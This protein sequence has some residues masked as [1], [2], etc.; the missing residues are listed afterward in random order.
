M[1]SKP[2]VY[3]ALKHSSGHVD[4]D[5]SCILSLVNQGNDQSEPAKVGQI[6][7]RK[8]QWED[9]HHL[10]IEDFINY[11]VLYNKKELYFPN[12]ELIIQATIHILDS[13]IDFVPNPIEPNDDNK[14]LFRTMEDAD[15]TI[16]TADGN[17]LKAHSNILS[18][19]SEIFKEILS[20]KKS[21]EIDDQE[22]NSGVVKEL[23]RFC[24]YGNGKLKRKKFSLELFRIAKKFFIHGLAEICMKTIY[25]EL[26]EFCPIEVAQLAKEYFMHDLFFNCGL[27][28]QV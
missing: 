19:S 2:L 23:L 14:K 10:G 8:N 22:F 27:L 1:K 28:I 15:V 9:I 6:F 11:N 12:G 4:F 13:T 7:V 20:Q 24:Y 21:F 5:L 3:I 25:E 16:K 18:E 17:T 26:D